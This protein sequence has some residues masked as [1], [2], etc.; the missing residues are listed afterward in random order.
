M[1][2]CLQSILCWSALFLG[3]ALTSANAADARLVSFAFSCD[4][5]AKVVNLNAGG[6]GNSVQ[7]FVQSAEI[8]VFDNP[9]SLSFAVLSALSDPTKTLLSLGKGGRRATNQFVFSLFQTPTSPS[10]NIPFTL[11]GS[12]LGGGVVQGLVTIDFFS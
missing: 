12:C 9:D 8:V 11:T 4:G 3:F 7:R 1:R 10:G 6:L 2:N 5:L